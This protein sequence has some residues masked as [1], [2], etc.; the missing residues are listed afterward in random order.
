MAAGA[1]L[2]R[3][4][5]LGSQEKRTWWAG[6]CS[7]SGELS[8]LATARFLHAENPRYTVLARTHE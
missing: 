1:V 2:C 7:A 4:C 5:F 3:R 6:G 8:F